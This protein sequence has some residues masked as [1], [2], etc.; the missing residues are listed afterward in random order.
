MA[1]FASRAA[2]RGCRREGRG[3][4]TAGRPGRDPQVGTWPEFNKLIGGFFKYHWFYPQ[5]ITV[6]IDDP[7]SPV[8]AMFHGQEFEIHDETYTFGMEVTRA[9]ICTY[10]P[11]SITTR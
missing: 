1:R 9:R 3:A 2:V 11:A 6:K 5:L 4:V 8:T 7:K 10:S